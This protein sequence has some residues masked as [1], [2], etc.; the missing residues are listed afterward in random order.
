MNI[1]KLELFSKYYQK[2]IN[3]NNIDDLMNN[4]KDQQAST[5][6]E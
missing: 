1:E 2:E 6:L 5:R 4:F 3:D